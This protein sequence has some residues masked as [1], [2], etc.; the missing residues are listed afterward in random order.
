MAYSWLEYLPQQASFFSF[1]QWNQNFL[2]LQEQSTCWKEQTPIF[3]QLSFHRFIHSNKRKVLETLWPSN[4][5]WSPCPELGPL[6]EFVNIPWRRVGWML[7]ILKKL[8]L[9]T[10]KLANYWPVSMLAF[11]VERLRLLK[12]L[13]WA[14]SHSAQLPHISLTLVNLVTVQTVLVSLRGDLLLVMVEHQV[15][16][17]PGGPAGF[18]LVTPSILTCAWDYWEVLWRGTDHSIFSIIQLSLANSSDLAGT[19]NC[20]AQCPREAEVWMKASWLKFNP[21]KTVV[22]L[23]GEEKQLEKDGRDNFLWLCLPSVEQVRNIG[24]LRAPVATWKSGSCY[25]QVN[26]S[27]PTDD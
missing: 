19:I 3:L 17:I 11:L 12:V 27:P 1:C 15:C 26:F 5:A 25:S 23:I 24:Q 16:I 10:K 20:T 21:H 18:Q 8:L 7:P 4:C 14:T 2:Y 13:Q 22:I 6:I 9:D